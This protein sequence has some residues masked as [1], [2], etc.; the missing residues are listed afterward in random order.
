M[1][2]FCPGRHVAT[3]PDVDQRIL[4]VR[5]LMHEGHAAQLL[6]FR[7]GRRTSGYE[8]VRP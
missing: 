8:A 1:I 4:Q 6:Q 7:R 5:D 2:L 3:I